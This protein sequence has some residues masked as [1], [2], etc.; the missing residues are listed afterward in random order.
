MAQEKGYLIAGVMTTVAEV[1]VTA[2]I[3]L[4]SKSDEEEAF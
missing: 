1:V 3:L 4:R 2:V